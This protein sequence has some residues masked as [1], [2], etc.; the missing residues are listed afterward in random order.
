MK[1]YIIKS[2][3]ASITISAMFMFGCFL[4]WSN[5]SKFFGYANLFVSNIVIYYLCI[6]YFGSQSSYTENHRKTKM[7]RMKN[8]IQK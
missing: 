8:E 7:M 2:V 1:S 6:K 4:I 5:I 3:I